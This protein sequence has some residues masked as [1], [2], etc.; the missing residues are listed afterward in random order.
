MS[1]QN[2]SSNK[3]SPIGEVSRRGFLKGMGIGTAATGVLSAA[4]PDA[5]AATRDSNI[6]G[7]GEMPVSL[8]VNGRTRQLN[9]EP[10]VTLLD[11]LRN[12]LDVT[13]PKK[14]CDRGTCGA[15]TVLVDGQPVYSCS[16]L[17]VEA[18]KTLFFNRE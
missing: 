6:K 17:A 11:A 5:E 9:V 4:R 18:G 15:C 3:S 1:E 2:E 14:V 10:R 8:K 12:R 7:P 16:L 13:G